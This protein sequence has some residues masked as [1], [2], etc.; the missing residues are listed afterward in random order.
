VSDC[1]ARAWAKTIKIFPHTETGLPTSPVISAFKKTG[2][3]LYS[4]ALLEKGN[5]KVA[6]TYKEDKAAAPSPAPP[7]KDA[8]VPPPQV[9][10]KA[11]APSAPTA[12]GAYPYAKEFDGVRRRKR[13]RAQE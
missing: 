10:K 5:F 1:I 6:E 7:P 3:Y 4:R 8:L 2:I 9:V 11:R 12:G 13:A